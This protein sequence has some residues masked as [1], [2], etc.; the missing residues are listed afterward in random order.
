MT[1][2]GLDTSVAVP[3]LVQTHRA[4]QAVVRWWAGREVALS[5]HALAETYS[6]LSAYPATCGWR[7]ADAARLLDERF[8]EPLLIG[9]QTAGRF[10]RCSPGSGSSAVRSTMRWWHSPPSSTAWMSPRGRPCPGD[11]RS[12]RR[13]CCCRR[14]TAGGGPPGLNRTTNAAS[15]LQQ[16]RSSPAP[17]ET[18]PDSAGRSGR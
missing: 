18:D 13:A 11:L 9:P 15:D 4:H 17:R 8:R 10:Q 12:R 5:G 1:A 7:P 3:L 16:A 2:L 14:L 6:V